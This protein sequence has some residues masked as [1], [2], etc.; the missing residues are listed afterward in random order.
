M[1]IWEKSHITSCMCYAS[2]HRLNVESNY[3]AIQDYFSIL[4]LQQ[5]LHLYSPTAT[6]LPEDVQE[7]GSF[8]L[9]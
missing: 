9:K 1:Q 7:M 6:P 4:I 5:N 2:P 8:P 3:R